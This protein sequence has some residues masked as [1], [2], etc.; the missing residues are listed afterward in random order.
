MQDKLVSD[1]SQLEARYA[2][3]KGRWRAAKVQQNINA[4]HDPRAVRMRHSTRWKRRQ[5]CLDEALAW[6]SF[7]GAKEDDLDDL[8]AELE[9]NMEKDEPPNGD[10]L[11]P[12]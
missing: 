4:G 10:S 6:P 2:E 9:K 12:G 11:C 1:M 5:P 3:L 8:I 7:A